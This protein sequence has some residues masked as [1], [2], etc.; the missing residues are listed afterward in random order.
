DLGLYLAKVEA[1]GLAPPPKELQDG[2]RKTVDVARGL[3]VTG[4][5]L[6]GFDT[7]HDATLL[8]NM[9][10]K[11]ETQL[12]RVLEVLGPV[13]VIHPILFKKMEQ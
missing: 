2:I 3:E 6:K 9:A 10:R 5:L 1:V 11:A 7:I 4:S 12:K 8:F 13:D